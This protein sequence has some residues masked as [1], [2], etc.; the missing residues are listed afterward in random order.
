M[1]GVTQQQLCAKVRIDQSTMAHTLKRME[2]DGLVRRTPDPADGRRAL[3]HLTERARRLR[4]ELH[5]AAREVNDLATAGFPAEDGEAF[6]RLLR[7][8]IHNLEG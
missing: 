7:Q 6:L 2:R 3:I 4:P 1:D 8:A 5:A